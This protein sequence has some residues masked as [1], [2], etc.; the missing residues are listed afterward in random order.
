[1]FEHRRQIENRSCYLG[2]HF[3]EH[4]AQQCQRLSIETLGFRVTALISERLRHVPDTLRNVDAVLA[5]SSPIDGQRLARKCLG[6]PRPPLTPS[7]C[8]DAV[9]RSRDIRMRC[10]QEATPQRERFDEGTLGARDVT[11][12]EQDCAESVQRRGEVGVTGGI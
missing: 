10:T 7:H 1:M 8:G 4:L 5:G 2:V 11:P 6:L 3:G 9:E 12:I